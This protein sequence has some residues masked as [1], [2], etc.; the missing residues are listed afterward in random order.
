[1][2]GKTG[3]IARFVVDEVA[4]KKTARI[5]GSLDLPKMRRLFSILYR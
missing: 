4:Q 3:I 1:M 2:F 5:Q